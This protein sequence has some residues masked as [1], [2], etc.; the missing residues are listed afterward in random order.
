MT[1]HEKQ[2]GLKDD[3]KAY[4]ANTAAQPGG[5]TP[6]Y[7]GAAGG[8][9]LGGLASLSARRG[10]NSRQ[11]ALRIL[12]NAV[13][14]GVLGGVGLQAFA[15]GGGAAVDSIVN[16]GKA[17]QKNKDETGNNKPGFG[18]SN[19]MRSVVYTGAPFLGLSSVQN[20][21]RRYNLG[22]LI[23][24]GGLGSIDF[25]LHSAEE[26]PQGGNLPKLTTATADFGKLKS[27]DLHDLAK[28]KIMIA[29]TEAALKHIRETNPKSFN[30]LLDAIAAQHADMPGSTGKNLKS[31]LAAGYARGRTG[32]RWNLNSLQRATNIMG[33]GA[34]GPW[35]RGIG[36]VL[37]IPSM[38]AA[39]HLPEL[40]DKTKSTPQE[41]EKSGIM[42]YL[43][44]PVPKPPPPPPPPQA[45]WLENLIGGRSYDVPGLK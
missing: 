35:R 43:L 2:S 29:D 5:F 3:I 24:K 11:R 17:Y 36:S 30:N 19:L 12:R 7:L 44:G 42:D 39:F 15:Q 16:I 21:L 34:R 6:G 13:G 20:R 4:F 9:A 32:S 37:S 23:P 33:S 18:S 25:T 31:F 14:G 28:R 22:K 27:K 38:I 41:E 10:E 45:P 8:A 26:I 40:I 1:T